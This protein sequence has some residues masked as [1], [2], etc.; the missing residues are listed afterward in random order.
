MSAWNVSDLPR[1]RSWRRDFLDAK[2]GV[3][4]DMQGQDAK[5]EGERSVRVCLLRYRRMQMALTMDMHL[6]C[7]KLQV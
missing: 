2:C 7:N 5:R 6:M 1:G 4:K 3:K